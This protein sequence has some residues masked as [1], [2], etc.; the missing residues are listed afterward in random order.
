MLK[1]IIII[2]GLIFL[3]LSHEVHSKDIVVQIHDGT[4]TLGDFLNACEEAA[5][6]TSSKRVPTDLPG[7]IITINNNAYEIRFFSFE[8]TSGKLASDTTFLDYI[9]QNNLL[10]LKSIVT[11]PLPNVK[12]ESFDFRKNPK[13]DGVYFSLALR[14]I[15]NGGSE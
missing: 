5:Q 9:K 6:C 3:P 12:F 15:E 14:Q 7:K 8:D 2:V 1:N 13:K 11:S 4:L 10:A